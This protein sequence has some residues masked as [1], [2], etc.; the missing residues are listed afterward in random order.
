MLT[1]S[2][3][4]V[5]EPHELDAAL[6]V[7]D[8]DPVSNAFVA[9]RVQVAGL[10][11]WRLGG[12]MWGWYSGGRLESLCYAGANLVPI[13]ATPEA[14]RGFAERARRA[15]RRCSS[16]V[17]PAE[18]TAGLW[19][20]LE[21]SWGP[22]RE[23]RA[24][25]P[26]MVTSSMPADVP[27]DPLVRRV[28][29]DEMDVIMPACVAMFTE[30]VGVSPLAGDGGLLYQ[31]RVAELVT[32]GR[33]FAR[34]ENG[35]VVFKAEIGA[36]TPQACQIQGVWVAPEYRGRGLS[37]TGMAAVLRYALSEVAPVVSLYVNDFNTAA[38]AAYRRV[39]FREVGA[40][41]SVLF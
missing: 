26:L 12:E 32:A 33:S 34:I 24:R 21:P 15:G 3:T 16:I 2:T 27:P 19:S 25:Q 37:E 20:L 13:C 10:D 17:G 23:V 38:R 5:L 1:T 14:V 18:T 9:A 40:F 7:L 11:P 28:R 39:G 35:R 41:M 6:A 36:A 29:R 31:A 4:R 8:R 22:A 30:E